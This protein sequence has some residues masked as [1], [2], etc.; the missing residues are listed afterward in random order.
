MDDHVATNREKQR[1]ARL[2]VA[3]NTLLVVLKLA[4]GFAIGSVAIIAEAVHSGIDLVAAVIAY[5][6]VRA[7]GQPP[8]TEHEFG[9]GSF[10]DLSGLIEGALIL[11]AAVLIVYEA[12]G[13]LLA[14]GEPFEPA[15]LA[16][17]VAVMAVSAAVNWYV[18][19]RLMR[20]GKA[21]DSIALESDAWHLRTD[22][23][24]SV[25]VFAGLIALLLTGIVALDALIAVAVAFVI[26][27][28]AYDLMRRASG[29][30]VDQRLPEDEEE[31]I[32]GI[33]AAHRDNIA[34]F[35]KLRTRRSGPDR[36]VDLH[37]C[38]ARGLTVEESHALADQLEA[39]IEAALPRCSA[40]I[41]VE[42][43][44]GSCDACGTFCTI[45]TV[46]EE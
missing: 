16:V 25:G 24:T 8:D 12:V 30:L 44:N 26:L 27:K 42:P 9:H 10:E 35:H 17:G 6:A 19:G 31:T 32:C 33:V 38:V 29:N 3:S 41:H 15:Q 20:V 4:V 22:V 36:F 21:T 13:K 39:E 11:V 37:L 43:C 2:S 14:G 40:T 1:V 28:A 7:S 34:E 46:P 5:F 18:S 23:Y 45:R